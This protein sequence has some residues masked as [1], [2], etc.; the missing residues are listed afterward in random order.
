MPPPLPDRSTRSTESLLLVVV[1]IWAANAPL[2]KF[3]ISGMD[4]LVFNSIRFLVAGTTLAAIYKA[5]APWKN[6]PKND[7]M[8]LIGL[9]IIA[10][11]LYQLTY[12]YGIKNTTVGNSA[13]ILST[14]PLWT[15]F[16]NSMIHK[17][18]VPSQTWLGTGVSLVGIIFIVIGTGS[19]VR[20][21]GDALFGDVLSLMAAVLW[22]LSTTL[23]KNFLKDYSAMQLSV[24]LVAIGS[25][26]LT[27]LAIPSALTMQWGAVSSGYYAA[28]VGSGALSIGASTVLWA[29]GIK[30]LGPRKTANFNNLVPVLAFVFAYIAIGEKMFPLQIIGATITLIGVWL[31]RR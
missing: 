22:A 20:I 23:Q 14:S 15:M 17:E 11:V 8:S 26:V 25:I 31:A 21:G 24:L 18:K 2:V 9:G 5:R 3:G 6:V 13:I 19:T 7:W 10:H 4:L 1:F 28:A 29:V 30:K 16:L 27:L 12:L